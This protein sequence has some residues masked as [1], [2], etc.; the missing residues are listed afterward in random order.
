MILSTW[1]LVLTLIVMSVVL[2]IGINHLLVNEYDICH[3]I[4]H[5]KLNY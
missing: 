5:C 3:A 2:A 4:A 1:I